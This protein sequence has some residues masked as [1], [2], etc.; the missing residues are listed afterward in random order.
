MYV[1]SSTTGVRKRI[2]QHLGDGH[3]DTS[4]LHLKY[5][6]SGSYEISITLY[7]EPRPIIQLI[8]DDMWD[9][10]RPA[11]GKQGKNNQSR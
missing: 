2:H 1:G 7:E 3:K 4:A 9:A 10:L 11:F 5:W 8:E 6:F